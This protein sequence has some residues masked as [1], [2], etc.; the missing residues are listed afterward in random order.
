M[1]R[2][3]SVT[4]RDIAERTGVTRMAVSLALRGKPG[5][6]EDTRTRVL[7]AAKEL[8][9][10]PD[11]EVAK[12]LSRIRSRTPAETRACLALLTSGES[13]AEWKKSV[14]ERKYV[15]GAIDRARR[16]GYRV[17]EFWVNKPGL[18]SNRLSS[19]IW[20]RGIEGVIIAPLQGRLS[21]DSPSS[22][23]LDYSLFSVVEISETVTWPDLDRS[24]HDQYTSMLR[25]LDELQS[26]QYLKIGLV[27]EKALDRRVNGKWTAAYLR[28]R[29]S[30][31]ERNMP[32]PL[33]LA[34]ADLKAFARWYDKHQPDAV[35]S[36]DRF[37][38]SM[39]REQGL[40]I[41]GDVAYASLDLDGLTGDEA[42]ISGIDQNSRQVGAAAVDMLVAAI[43]RGERGIP[44]HPIRTEIEG[45]WVMGKSTPRRKPPGKQAAS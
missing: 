8:G 9:Y 16:Y 39:I 27:L 20:N 21:G 32:P 6:S 7:A 26:L 33:L 44:P 4:L 10:E 18:S 43:Q 14:T 19:I 41:P 31:G 15:E 25:L 13:P 12:L 36:V 23:D 40:S 45:T 37:G 3:S 2:K 1:N 34:K 28:H 17:E 30:H 5:V 11:P 38:L 24:I 22:I 29:L 42:G 35:I